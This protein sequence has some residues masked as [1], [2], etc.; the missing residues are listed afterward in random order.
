MK[1]QWKYINRCLVCGSKLIFEPS[2]RKDA[3]PEEGA[4][5][6]QLNHKRFAVVG[7]YNVDGGWSLYYYLPESARFLLPESAK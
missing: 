7:S 6:C 2:T 4:K 5:A 3:E 1:N